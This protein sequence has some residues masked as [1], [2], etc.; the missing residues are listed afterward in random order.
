[1]ASN[2]GVPTPPTPRYIVGHILRYPDKEDTLQRTQVEPSVIITTTIY[3]TYVPVSFY[4]GE[5]VHRPFCVRIGSASA[6]LYRMSY[7]ARDSK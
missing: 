6:T 4:R 2:Q 7:L 3:C 5:F 1:M